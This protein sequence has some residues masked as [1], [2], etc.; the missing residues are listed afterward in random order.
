MAFV[1]VSRRWNEDIVGRSFLREALVVRL[2]VL[3][4][5]D[6]WLHFCCQPRTTRILGLRGILIRSFNPRLVV[7][8][9]TAIIIRSFHQKTRFVLILMGNHNFRRHY[10]KAMEQSLC[11]LVLIQAT[12]IVHTPYANMPMAW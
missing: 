11:E 3:Y 2:A 5:V 4:F 12:A 7:V 10:G 1:L 9:T 8:S 6:V